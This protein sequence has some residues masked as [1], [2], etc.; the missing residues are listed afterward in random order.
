[1]PGKITVASKKTDISTQPHSVLPFAAPTNTETDRL[2]MLKT[3]R[4]H[5]YAR[6]RALKSEA[7]SRKA[8]KGLVDANW[9]SAEQPVARNGRARMVAGWQLRVEDDEDSIERRGETQSDWVFAADGVR[10]RLERVREVSLV[11]IMKPGKTR[12][13]EQ[14]VDDFEVVPA[15]PTVIALDETM[16]SEP[17]AVEEVWEYLELNDEDEERGGHRALSY[18]EIAANAT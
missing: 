11:E 13:R 16:A 2:S 5:E 17:E 18:A 9:K 8:K 6:N 1:M 3:L 12:L 15:V 4:E 7:R 14:S 10:D